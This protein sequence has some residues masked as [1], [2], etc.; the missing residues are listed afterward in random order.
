L[1]DTRGLHHNARA[2]AQTLRTGTPAGARAGG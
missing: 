1:R 2:T